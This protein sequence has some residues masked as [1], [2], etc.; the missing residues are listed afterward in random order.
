MQAGEGALLKRI[1]AVT[2][3]PNGGSVKF[4]VPWVQKVSISMR[5]LCC[6]Y[7]YPKLARKLLD[8]FCSNLQK[9]ILLKHNRCTKIYMSPYCFNSG[10]ACWAPFGSI[11]LKKGF[12]VQTTTSKSVPRN[13]ASGRAGQQ[14]YM[15][16]PQPVKWLNIPT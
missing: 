10:C 15:R 13:C 7:V 2:F 12:K 4:E 11:T 9:I 5:R 16:P 14:V 8:R 6:C 3:I 1:S